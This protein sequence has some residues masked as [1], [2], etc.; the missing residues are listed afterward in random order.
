MHG[1]VAEW[2]KDAMDWEFYSKPAARDRNPVC[3]EGQKV[4]AGCYTPEDAPPYRVA[5]GGDFSHW[6]I[7]VRS[8]KRMAII[9]GAR[10]N[11]VGFRPVFNLTGLR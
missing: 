6:A 7:G 8:A 5:R 9:P 11:H 1:N 4:T 3:S 2:C 10:L